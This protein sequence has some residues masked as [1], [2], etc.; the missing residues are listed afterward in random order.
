MGVGPGV[1]VPAGVNGTFWR[2]VLAESLSGA[3]VLDVGTGAGKVALAVAPLCKRVVGIDRDASA[4]A[5]AQRRAVAAGVSNAEFIAADADAIDHATLV[6]EAPRLVTAHMYLS[7]ALVQRS[8]AVL[9]PRGAL[10][11]VGFHVDQWKE[12]GKP[13]R[14][15]YDEER[16]RWVLESAA[17]VVEHVDVEREVQTFASVEQA[18]AAAIGLQDR[19]QSDGRW[20]QYLRFLEEGGRTLTR[21]L[22]VVKA[23][24]R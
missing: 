21:S 1:D 7:D 3:H 6:A 14:F 11:M 10:V 15:A 24:R 23:R 19:W 20:A 5:E 17:L 22:V 9:A 18:L 16:M 2:H 13:S 8:A 4:I 12:T